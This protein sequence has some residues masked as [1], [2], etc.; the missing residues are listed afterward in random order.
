MDP[1]LDDQR[2]SAR[3]RARVLRPGVTT[4]FLVAALTSSCLH[5]VPDRIAAPIHTPGAFSESGDAPA[6]SRWWESFGDD[7]L[8]RLVDRTLAGNLDLQSAWARLTQALAMARRVGAEGKLQVTGD[9]GAKRSR[10]AGPI[11]SGRPSRK[12]AEIYTLE[13]SAS[14]ELD[15]WGRVR[16]LRRAAAL[17]VT[18]SR[19]DVDAAAMTLAATVADAWFTLVEQRAQEKLIQE[20]QQVSQTYLDLVEIRFGQGQATALDVY[21]QRTQ[22]ANTRSQLPPVAARREVLEHQLAVLS[23]RPPAEA[24]AR[25]A[26]ALPP[27]P[28]LPSAGVPVEVLKRRPDVRAAHTR[29][30]AAD[31]RVA[32]AVADRWP[33][34][35]LTGSSLYQGL[36]ASRM[37]DIW[38]W[39]IAGSLIQPLLDGG[40]RRAE[41]ERHRALVQE[42]L[43]TYGQA[44][45]NAL[46]EVED[47]LAQERQH[48]RLVASLTAQLRL[49]N[50][51]LA[52]ARSHYVNGL[53]D[54]LPVLTALQTSQGLE[55]SL[56]QA[57]REQIGYRIAL[58]RALG[59]DWTRD[60][61]APKAKPV[62]A[63]KETT[64]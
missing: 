26:D 53:T 14:Y 8:N 6:P 35:Q 17:D 2:T 22:V 43:L 15:L 46:R 49:A 13:L 36:D 16:S 62:V 18:S 60:L 59:G 19:E 32:A 7:E 51:T 23:G 34:L 33:S 25:P 38:G 52:Q 56:L 12:T 61:P 11:A 63:D 45:L 9:L 64:P 24:V 28:P 44:I 1:N 29:L 42:Q 39:S 21:Q 48:G 20:Q 5:R 58:H 30:K 54:Y 27:L 57:K 10:D 50:A 3:T 47:A 40:Y 31:H 37:F 55:R 41:V 4:V